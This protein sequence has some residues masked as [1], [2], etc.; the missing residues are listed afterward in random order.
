MDMEDFSPL[1]DSSL[2]LPASV[3][4]VSTFFG[5]AEGMKNL[6]PVKLAGLA[7][8][9]DGA[10]NKFV[11]TPPPLLKVSTYLFRERNNKSKASENEEHNQQ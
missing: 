6:A 2:L 10:W 3:A 7:N 5:A 8:A 11:D 9:A 4:E 1:S